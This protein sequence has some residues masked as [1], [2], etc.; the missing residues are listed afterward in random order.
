M[1]SRNCLST[2]EK[3]IT[4]SKFQGKVNQHVLP[5]PEMQSSEAAYTKEGGSLV[6]G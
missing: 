3:M 5:N 6:R 1:R 4:E 2:T